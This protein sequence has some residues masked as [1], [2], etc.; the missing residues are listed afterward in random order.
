M[1]Q[2]AGE[3]Q[4]RADAAEREER[5]AADANRRAHLARERAASERK[6]LTIRAEAKV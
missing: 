3:V 1:N 2:E 6:Q 5:A 4:G